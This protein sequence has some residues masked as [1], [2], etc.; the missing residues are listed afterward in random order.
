MKVSINILCAHKV[1]AQQKIED[2]EEK[3]IVTKMMLRRRLTRNSKI[4]LY[5]ADKCN[6]SSGKVVYASPFGELQA[7]A[8]ITQSILNE[9][10]ISPTLFQN[11]VYNTAPSYFSLL[12]ENKDEIITVSSGNNSSRDALKTA[13]L[14]ALVSGEKVLCVG[15]ECLDIDKISE[16]NSCTSY[17]E[18]GAAVVLEIAR[19]DTNTIELEVIKEEGIIESL[20][21]LFSLVK[22][23]NMGNKQVHIEL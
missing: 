5:L 20:Q 21:D 23:Y 17:L 4:M 19:E 15:T 13:A 10:Q 22:M 3:R 7:T 11:S 1:Y 12:H 18:S 14:Q 2:L 6:F 9:E 8:A 16:V